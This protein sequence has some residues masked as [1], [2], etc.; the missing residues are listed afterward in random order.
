MKHEMQNKEQPTNY[1]NIHEKKQ[2]PLITLISTDC[3]F[4]SS[5]LPRFRA[6]CF[7]S[8]FIIQHSSFYIKAP[9]HKCR[10]VIG[11]DL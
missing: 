7:S 3:F 2:G 1:S 10:K 8:S 11:G 9:I 6:S 5:A 4:R